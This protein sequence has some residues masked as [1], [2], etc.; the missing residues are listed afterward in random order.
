MNTH[1]FVFETAA[2]VAVELSASSISR[3]LDV[4]PLTLRFMFELVEEA[5]QVDR[6][7]LIFRFM[8]LKRLIRKA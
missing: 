5:S 7:Y 6:M 3:Q 4:L 1:T 8:L 2:V